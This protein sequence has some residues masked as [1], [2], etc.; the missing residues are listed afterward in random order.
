[1]RRSRRARRLD[2]GAQPLDDGVRSRERDAG[3]LVR[4]G[5]IGQESA[6]YDR[7]QMAD[8]TEHVRTLAGR[9][10]GAALE[11][12]PLRAALLAGSGARGDADFY[13]DLDL[14]LYVDELPEEDRLERLRKALGGTNLVPIA[15]PHLVQ[16]EVGGVAVQ[17]GYQTVEQMDADLDAALD[18]IEEIVDSPNQ[19]MLSG[20]VEGHAVHGDEVIVRWR[21]RAAAYP[22]E[23]RRAAIAQ[24]WRFF[25]LW[26]YGDAME[27]RDSE[28]WR[29]DML[30]DGA[31]NLLAV[32][33]ALNRVYFAR[34][35]LKRL[36]A[37]VAKLA[38]APPDLA[39]RVE[40]LFRLPAGDAAEEL[41]RLV[42]ETRELVLREVP[43]A[44]VP[45]RRPPGV[46]IQPW[47]A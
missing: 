14:L 45:L 38:I 6:V 46:R 41:G 20:L 2:R 15:P 28:L 9:V 31:F 29:L 23:L 16:F 17:V 3:G 27:R 34:F 8:A 26:Y 30:L 13:S 21:E 11:L 44:E 25:P 10:V 5:V 32:L 18:R 37:L 39:D 19:K 43:D 22:D 35:E 1:M 24:H 12:G 4:A 36:R 33:A 42:V 47:S 7:R 40:S